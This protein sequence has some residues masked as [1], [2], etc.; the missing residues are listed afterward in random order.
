M[1]WEVNATVATSPMQR[2]GLAAAASSGHFM[3]IIDGGTLF[4]YDAENNEWKTM[5]NLSHVTD[6]AAL[7]VRRQAQVHIHC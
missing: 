7:I 3:W 1:E 4:R 6:D 2:V 5:A